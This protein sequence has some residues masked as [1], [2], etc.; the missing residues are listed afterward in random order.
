MFGIVGIPI[1]E[2]AVAAQAVGIKYIGM[3]NEQAACNTA[4]AVG[5]LTGKPR[6]CLIVS[7]SG[8]LHA[9]GGMNCWPLIVIRG[10]LTEIRKPWELSKNFHR[11]KL[12]GCTTNYLSTQ[13][14]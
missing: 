13:A 3:R 5:Y 10:F 4:S 11:L 7:G 6:I 14:A 1:T 2:I 12:V 8:F 9:L